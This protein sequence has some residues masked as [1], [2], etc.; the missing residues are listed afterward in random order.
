[1]FSRLESQSHKNVHLRLYAADG[2]SFPY[3]VTVK[4]WAREFQYGKQV[5][6]MSLERSGRRLPNVTMENIAS[7]N[8]ITKTRRFKYIKNF[9]TKN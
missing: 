1:M 2:E 6:K 7:V 5:L 9:T 8:S 4:K 3:Y